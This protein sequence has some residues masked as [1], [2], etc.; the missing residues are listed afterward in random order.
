MASPH[1]CFRVKRGSRHTTTMFLP[2]NC[3]GP[4]FLLKSKFLSQF[5]YPPEPGKTNAACSVG[6]NSGG[7]AKERRDFKKRDSIPDK[8]RLYTVVRKRSE[9][10][11]HSNKLMVAATTV[12][13]DCVS[14]MKRDAMSLACV[15]RDGVVVSLPDHL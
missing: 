7:D 12:L 15:M 14:M 10:S 2:I 13:C 11:K 5:I 4:H 8:F 1:N 3:C 6:G 9:F